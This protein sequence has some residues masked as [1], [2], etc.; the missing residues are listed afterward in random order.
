M[1]LYLDEFYHEIIL[2]VEQHSKVTCTFCIQ[3]SSY[4]MFIAIASLVY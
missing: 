3:T 1:S 2:T 4:S